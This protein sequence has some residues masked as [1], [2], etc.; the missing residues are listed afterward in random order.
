MG[1]NVAQ[2]IDVAEKT[3]ADGSDY[4]EFMLHSSEF[5]PG[6]SPTF[7]TNEHIETLYDDL[8]A[9]FEWLQSRTVGRTLSEYYQEKLRL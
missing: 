6:G 4:V 9:L 3:L 5:M 2:M 1:G 8:E 7:K